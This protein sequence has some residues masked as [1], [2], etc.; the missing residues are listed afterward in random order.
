MDRPD[1]LD[2]YLRLHAS[3]VHYVPLWKNF[4][5]RYSAA[6]GALLPSGG[7]FARE[8]LFSLGGINSYFGKKSLRAYMGEAIELTAPKHIM[9]CIRMMYTVTVMFI[10]ITYAMFGL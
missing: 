5:V 6:A 3:L 1:S 10:I 9:E 4:I 2:S 7:A 8:D